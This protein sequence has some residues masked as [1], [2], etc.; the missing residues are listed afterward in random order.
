MQDITLAGIFLDSATILGT[1]HLVGAHITAQFAAEGATFHNPNGTAIN[2]QGSRIGSII[3]RSGVGH[4]DVPIPGRIDGSL[5][6]SCATVEHHVEISG[7][8][9][10]GGPFGALDGRGMETRGRFIIG[11]GVHVT[12]AILLS[13]V[14]IR[15]SLDLSGSHIRSS[16]IAQDALGEAAHGR[17]GIG[18]DP[19][20]FVALDLS[21]SEI[22]HLIMP[23]ATDI[24]YPGCGRPRGIVDLS[25]LKVGTYVDFASAWPVPVPLRRGAGPDRFRDGRDRDAD[26]LILDG[27]E[28]QHLDNPDG[29]AEPSVPAHTARQR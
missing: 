12:G 20:H 11:R 9:L 23:D 2:A 3:L 25:R 21:E 14:E 28:Y 27:F 15:C 6:F 22:S 18:D 16:A 24:R 29:D 1:C 26:H 13:G 19:L 4:G 17:L 8:T 7:A 5:N 10:T